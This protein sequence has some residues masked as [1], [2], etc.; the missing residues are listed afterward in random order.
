MIENFE[1]IKSQL[2]ELAE[3]INSFTSETVQLRIVDLIFNASHKEDTDSE[4]KPDHEAIIPKSRRKKVKSKT[5]AS[6]T[7][8]GAVPRKKPA[9]AGQ[10]PASTLAKLAE[11]NFFDTPQ[12]MK[13]II[14][15]CEVNLARKIKQNDI[16][17]KL[18]RM[19]RESTLKRAKN[20]DGQYE[21]S[22]P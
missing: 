15:H 19:V 13:S 14:E 8:N 11:G 6:S 20:S 1:K 9:A 3:V 5:T 22:K 18:A 16:S 2:K 17:G 4:E 12:S 21:Y 7:T 10:G